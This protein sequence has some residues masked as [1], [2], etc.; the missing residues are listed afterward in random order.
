MG[1][2]VVGVLS[3]VDAAASRVRDDTLLRADVSF[4]VRDCLLEGCGIVLGIPVPDVR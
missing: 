1:V 4:I 2:G 3:A